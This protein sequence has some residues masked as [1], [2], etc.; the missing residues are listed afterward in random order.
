MMLDLSPTLLGHHGLGAAVQS[1]CH[2]SAKQAG[3]DVS[4]SVTDQRFPDL[5]EQLAYRATR[6]AVI[7]AARH[8]GATELVVCLE[9][10]AISTSRAGPVRGRGCGSGCRSPRSKLLRSGRRTWSPRL[11]RRVRCG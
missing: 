9:S 6:E 10:A 2:Q 8:S 7:N 3:L 11:T 4:L 5:V 1:L